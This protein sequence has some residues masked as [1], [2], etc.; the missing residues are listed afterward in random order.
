M[1]IV[2]VSNPSKALDMVDRTWWMNQFLMRLLSLD[3][4]FFDKHWHAQNGPPVACTTPYFLFL[5]S[6]VKAYWGCR[7]PKWRDLS[8]VD[9]K[10]DYAAKDWNVVDVLLVSGWMA[11]NIRGRWHQAGW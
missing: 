8:S 2:P 11:G 10:R 1:M 7:P 4:N 9:V 5:E 6:Y 3:Q